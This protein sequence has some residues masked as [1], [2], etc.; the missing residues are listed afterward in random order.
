MKFYATGEIC[1]MFGLRQETLF[2]MERVGKIK[3]I[4]RLGNGKRIF[5]D[6]NVR[7]IRKAV[8]AKKN[9]KTRKRHSKP[10][11]PTGL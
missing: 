2:Y 9:G 11:G 10:F 3:P 8:S 6:K 4:D 7:D 1:R 5:T